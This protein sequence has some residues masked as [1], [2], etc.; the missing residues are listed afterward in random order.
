MFFQ[1]RLSFLCTKTLTHPIQLSFYHK[2]VCCCKHTQWEG[3]SY[4]RHVLT[5][6]FPEP[7]QTEQAPGDSRLGQLVEGGEYTKREFAKLLGLNVSVRSYGPEWTIVNYLYSSFFPLQL[8]SPKGLKCIFW[9]PC[10]SQ[11]LLVLLP[12]FQRCCSDNMRSFSQATC[13]TLHCFS[14]LSSYLSTALPCLE[15]KSLGD[16][17]H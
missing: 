13:F 12:V 2:Q 15:G 17:W 1:R 5:C 6:S 4:L 8:R 14:F 16:N 9:L 7:G 11:Q 10:C 3:N